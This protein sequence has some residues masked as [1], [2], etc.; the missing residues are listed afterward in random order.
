MVYNR[1]TDFRQSNIGL[2]TGKDEYNIGGT[3][4]VIQNKAFLYFEGD[5]RQV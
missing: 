4:N 2:V 1:L 3:T 5:Y